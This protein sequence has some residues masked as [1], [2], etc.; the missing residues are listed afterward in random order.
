MASVDTFALSPGFLTAHYLCQLLISNNCQIWV[1]YWGMTGTTDSLENDKHLKILR[2]AYQAIRSLLSFF[3]PSSHI[4]SE[5]H[6]ICLPSTT[7]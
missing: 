1:S 3:S 6:Y 7:Q 5:H 2:V 4:S